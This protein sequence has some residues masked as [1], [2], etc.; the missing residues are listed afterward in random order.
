MFENS[1]FY[2]T[3][4]QCSSLDLPFISQ[5]NKRFKDLCADVKKL[6]LGHKSGLG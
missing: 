5:L 1:F 4:N 3:Y 6:T 2:L